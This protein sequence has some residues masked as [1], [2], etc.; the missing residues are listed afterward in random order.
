VPRF[1]SATAPAVARALPLWNGTSTL[2]SPWARSRSAI[3]EQK[4][5]PSHRRSRVGRGPGAR[6]RRRWM[7]ARP[8]TRRDPRDRGMSR[9]PSTSECRSRR[10][11]AQETRKSPIPQ[12]AG[13]TS[14]SWRAARAVGRRQLSSAGPSGRALRRQRDRRS[15]GHARAKA[16][17][18]HVWA[19]PTLRT[20]RLVGSRRGAAAGFRRERGA[21]LTAA[22]ATKQRS[23]WAHRNTKPFG[24]TRMWLAVVYTGGTCAG[25]ASS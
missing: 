3:C 2:R 9:V 22:G 13:Q 10:S 17:A 5:P 25:G 6:R 15:S 12:P 21:D 20:S 4:S 14:G 7:D 18:R 19:L 1:A 8:G 24:L 23:L 16:I 11:R